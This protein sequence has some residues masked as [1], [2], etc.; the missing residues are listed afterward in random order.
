MINIYVSNI[1]QGDIEKYLKQIKYMYN[2]A[3]IQRIEN[4]PSKHYKLR[5]ITSRLMLIKI[6]EDMNWDQRKLKQIN[7]TPKGKL[8]MPNLAHN[9][10]ISYVADVA[11]CLVSN[12]KIGIDAEDIT[13]KVTSKNI[14]LLESLTS[15]KIQSVIDFY[16]LWTRIESIV[17][18]YDSKGLYKIFQKNFLKHKKHY[19]KHFMVNKNFMITLSSENKI[20]KTKKFK[21]INVA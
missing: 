11:I 6:F 18:I 12:S 7:H 15:H 1:I 21:L 17:K 10:S 16:M 9:I 3:T 13:K 20:E 19:T 2:D 5:R 4:A 14:N 8:K